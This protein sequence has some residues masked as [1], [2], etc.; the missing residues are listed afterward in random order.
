MD[1]RVCSKHLRWCIEM[2]MMR[3]DF[4]TNIDFYSALEVVKNNG[5]FF[6]DSLKFSFDKKLAKEL[7]C[8]K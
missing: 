8:R 4:S 3:W 1:C 7:I 6:H 2:L 5:Q